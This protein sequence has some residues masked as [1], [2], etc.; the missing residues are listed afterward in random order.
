MMNFSKVIDSIKPK[1]INSG[2]KLEKLSENFIPYACHYSPDTILTKNGELLQIIK[3]EGFYSQS[4]VQKKIREAV[5]QHINNDDIAVTI[6]TVRRKKPILIPWNK[7]LQKGF[8]YNLHCSWTKMKKSSVEYVNEIYISLISKSVSNKFNAIDFVFSFSFLYIK[9]KYAKHLKQQFNNLSKVTEKISNDLREFKSH[10]LTLDEDN[11]SELLQLFRMF[12][13]LLTD[14]QKHKL[15]MEDI[16]DNLI[17]NY[18]IAIGFNSL[19]CITNK[20]KKRFAT[21]L[22]LKRYMAINI[23]NISVALQLNM[24]FIATEIVDFTA[25]IK[26]SKKIE[27]QNYLLD[28]SRASELQEITKLGD[29]GTNSKFMNHSTS[30]MPI[31]ASTNELE[32]NVIMLVKSLSECGIAV[33]RHDISLENAFLGILPANFNFQTITYLNSESNIGGL[34][35]LHPLNSGNIMCKKWGYAITLFWSVCNKPYF[36][37]F[38]HNEVGHTTIVGKP[39]SGSTSLQNFMISESKKIGTRVVIMEKNMKSCVFI[40]ALGGQYRFIDKNNLNISFNPFKIEE[41]VINKRFIFEL[42]RHISSDKATTEDIEIACKKIFAIPIKERKVDEISK[43][44]LPYLDKGADKLFKENGLFDMLSTNNDDYINIWENNSIGFNIGIESNKIVLLFTLIILNKVENSLDGKPTIIV[45]DEAWDIAELFLNVGYLRNF[46]N[47]MNKLNCVVIFTSSN[48]KLTL[49]S[50]F[51]QNLNNLISTQIFLPGGIMDKRY[52]KAF[53]IT[54]EDSFMIGTLQSY[55]K[56]FFLK[57]GDIS[58]VLKL[59]LGEMIEGTLLSSNQQ[60]IRLM[61]E[62][63]TESASHDP[64]RWLPI[65]YA[66]LG[67]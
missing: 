9:S 64:D 14:T 22:G 18:N 7:N 29:F 50:Q 63:I 66:K 52:I 17:R 67:K 47:R 38:H 12:I 10:I 16:A 37:N 33:F 28:V 6:N 58:I 4:D 3:L 32:E 1:E 13:T 21:V 30:I 34:A 42:I 59:D 19:E 53:N 20:T 8:A 60:K 41:S 54:K 57:Q 27:Y 24:E 35:F 62:A 31:A 23:N 43:L 46:L 45:L 49:S 5:S 26:Q 56:H 25:D 44:L 36:F 15:P 39:E 65:L 40:N 48:M 61:N 55:N 11:N 51:T 2:I